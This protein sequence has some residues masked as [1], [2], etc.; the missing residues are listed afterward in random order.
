MVKAI[1]F[2]IGGTLAEGDL[3]K[4]AFASMVIE[5]LS[6]LGFKVSRKAYK[7]S[8]GLAM[9]KLQ[10][11]RASGREMDFNSFYSLVLS[12]IGVSP[13]EELLSDLR[14]LYFRCFRSELIPGAEDV[15]KALSEEYI[16]GVVSNALTEW[17]RV[18]LEA[19]GLAEYFSFIIVSCDVGWRKPHRA[20][21]ELA[22][23]KLGL[24]ANQVA[25]VGDSPH[26]DLLGAKEIGMKA[27]LVLGPGAQLELLGV[28]P[29]A[30][31][32]HIKELPGVLEALDP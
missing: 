2:D 32:R 23:S 7:R 18:F 15:I 9:R 6:G 22:L 20:I 26:E 10:A 13:D 12:G 25:H 3:D 11:V 14:A 19:V 16:I 29:D 17:P 27:V 8:L 21:F 24:P 28:E 30:T 4:K 1:T 31:L 5:Y